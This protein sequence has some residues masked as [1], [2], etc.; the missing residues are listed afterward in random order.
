MTPASKKTALTAQRKR[1]YTLLNVA[2]NELIKTRAYFR[3]DDYREILRQCGAGLSGH[4][5]SATTMTV[6]ELQ[7]ALKR[8]QLLGFKAKKRKATKTTKISDWRKPR[9]AK[10]NAMWIAMADAG[11]VGDR[12]ES[13][14]Q[15]WCKNRIEGLSALQWATSPQLNKLIEMMK[16]MSQERGANAR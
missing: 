4:R 15:T 16:A 6:E 1:L 9:I 12:S 2:K 13:A 3:D 11:V 8:L 7:K 5:I 10:L 14:M